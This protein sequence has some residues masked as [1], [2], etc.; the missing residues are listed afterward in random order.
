MFRFTEKEITI[1]EVLEQGCLYKN[2][3]EK[4]THTHQAMSEAQFLE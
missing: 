2:K 4:H 1:L 3:G